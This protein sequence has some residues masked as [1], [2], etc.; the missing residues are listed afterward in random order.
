MLPTVDAAAVVL[1]V[2]LAWF[3]VG[4]GVGVDLATHV[5]ALAG[6]QVVVCTVRSKVVGLAALDGLQV[7][8]VACSQGG[9]A[10]AADLGSAKIEVFTRTG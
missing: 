6:Q 7:Q 1:L 4:V 5:L 10:C 8:V 3:A 2:L 9:V